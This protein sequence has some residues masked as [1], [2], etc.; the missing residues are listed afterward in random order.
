M[1]A[2]N[3]ERSYS[4]NSNNLAET[5]LHGNCTVQV[6]QNLKDVIVKEGF[7]HFF[8]YNWSGIYGLSYKH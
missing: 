5:P 2:S 6:P 8:I 3:S 7:L 4:P 1:N